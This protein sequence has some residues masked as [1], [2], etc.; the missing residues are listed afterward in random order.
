[1]KKR[2]IEELPAIPLRKLKRNYYMLVAD[3]L[4]IGGEEHLICDIY[5]KDGSKQEWILRAAYTNHDW[6]LWKP[7]KDAGG[8]SRRSIQDD[9]YKPVPI[10]DECE[11]ISGPGIPKHA[12]WG[13]T[14]LDTESRDIIK[15]FCVGMDAQH[16]R[17]ITPDEWY[18]YLLCI[19][20][21]IREERRNKEEERRSERLNERIRNMPDIPGDFTE[22]ADM[23]IFRRAE[24]VYY[25]RN[26]S[27]A[28][29]TCSKCG[30]EY[31][32]R[33]KRP[34]SFEGMFM[35]VEPVPENG[36]LTA[37]TL[38]GAPAVYKPKGRM[39]FIRG[40]KGYAYLIQPYKETATVVRYFEVRKE[41]CLNAPSRVM[42]N[43]IGRT[44]YDAYR[45]IKTDWYLR[46]D[47]TGQV[48]WYDH[49]IGGMANLS[50]QKGCVYKGN[51]KEWTT[52]RL[53]YCGLAEYARAVHDR[54]KP[55]YYL[56]F[57]LDYQLE[58]L[59]KLGMVN[60]TTA[61][62]GGC[63]GYFHKS[64]NGKVED[65][66]RI[67][68]SRLSMLSEEDDMDLLKVLQFERINTRNVLCGIAN[69][70]GRG[71][72]SVEQI[73]KAWAMRLNY[74][75]HKVLL[76]YMSVTQLINRVE[77]Y[78]GRP[79]IQGAE[80]DRRAKA[81]ADLYADY[82]GVRIKNDM[83][84]ERSTSIF[85]KDLRRAHDDAVLLA[86]AAEIDKRAAEFE[87]KYPEIKRRFRK[88]KARY[89][90]RHEDLFVRPAKNVREII[91]EGKI[92]HHCVGASD[93]YVSRHASGASFILFLR[94]VT[95][96]NAPY[97]TIE[98]QGDVIVQW[99]GRNDRKPDKERIEEWLDGWIKHL[100]MKDGISGE[101]DE[102]AEQILTT[103]G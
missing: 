29:C 15:K 30:E 10:Y 62:I 41:W 3:A 68:R 19:E 36:K 71:E 7:D 13:N 94:H 54:I 1:M 43:E 9:T 44:F 60:I 56:N 61:L 17:Y 40:E 72:W 45:N 53:K 97:I 82:F 26:G 22:W 102:A 63:E 69:A 55:C 11:M 75:R 27:F 39:K 4:S 100:R 20:D 95:D 47:M 32:I 37:C 5:R 66:L 25:K 96:P 91:E 92:L 51:A 8:W 83:D 76:E 79:V 80:E 59:V 16:H 73:E 74:G 46:D 24:Y 101:L 93:T 35:N 28:D 78:M 18:K 49:N 98:I 64:P 48:G 6:S 42:A 67:R 87:E 89:G 99:Y 70:K 52:K 12:G 65:I 90:Y 38:C 34:N 23:M 88:L 86:N 50:M 77:R 2:K 84:M 81:L 21:E 31:T 103:A 57:A 58:K 85:P 33:T 14:S